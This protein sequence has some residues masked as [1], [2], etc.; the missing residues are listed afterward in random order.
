ML[1]AHDSLIYKTKVRIYK[2]ALIGFQAKHFLAEIH[3]M[4]N[5]FSNPLARKAVLLLYAM[6]TGR[7]DAR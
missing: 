1:L 2:M 6:P 4:A 3:N 7:A 5:R